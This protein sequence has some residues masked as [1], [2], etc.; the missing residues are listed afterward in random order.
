MVHLLSLFLLVPN[1]NLSSHEDWPPHYDPNPSWLM[2]MREASRIIEEDYDDVE[3]VT[4][5]HISFP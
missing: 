5:P 3:R 4:E 1:K 2:L